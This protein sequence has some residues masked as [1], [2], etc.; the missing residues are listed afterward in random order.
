MLGPNPGNRHMREGA[1]HLGRQLTR[2]PVRRAVG[3]V[4]FSRPGRHACFETLGDFIT[5]AP[6]IPGE[7]SGQPSGLEPLAPATDG[8]VAAIQLRA[9]LGPGEALG[10]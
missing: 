2:G 7:Q 4:A 6:S 10:Y 8:A 5:P 1:A 3:R 9:T